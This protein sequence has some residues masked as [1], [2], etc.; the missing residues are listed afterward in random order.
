MEP[1]IKSRQATHKQQSGLQS[2]TMLQYNHQEMEN[3][4]KAFELY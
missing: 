4:C 1:E 2:S 3:C